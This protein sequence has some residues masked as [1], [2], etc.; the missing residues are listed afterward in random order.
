MTRG[1]PF[2]AAGWGFTCGMVYS[3]FFYQLT[4]LGEPDPSGVSSVVVVFIKGIGFA[5]SIAALV[6]ALRWKPAK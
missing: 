1:Q 6:G 3:S 4:H 5:L 2:L